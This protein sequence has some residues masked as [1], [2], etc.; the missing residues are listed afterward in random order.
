MSN[1]LHIEA[2]NYPPGEKYSKL[3][4]PKELY[5][6]PTQQLCISI[7]VVQDAASF[8]SRRNLEGS[9]ASSD[10]TWGGSVDQ[11]EGSVALEDAGYTNGCVTGSRAGG[12][13]EVP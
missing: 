8:V 4:H 6:T 10:A 2:N 5:P 12:P 1:R 11:K 9:V 13:P 3:H 7:R